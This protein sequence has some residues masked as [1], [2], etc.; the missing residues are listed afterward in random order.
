[1]SGTQ[2]TSEVEFEAEG[3]QQGYLRVPHS[4]HR[5]AYGWVPVPDEVASCNEGNVVAMCAMAR[6]RRGDALYEIAA[7][8][9]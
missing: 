4:V 9:D 1:M 7:D 2:I 5:S 8:A 6:V 3:K